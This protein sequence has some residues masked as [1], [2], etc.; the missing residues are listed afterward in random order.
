MTSV[1][2]SLPDTQCRLD[3]LARYHH[4]PGAVLAVSK[5]S[6][7]LDFA[8]GT[9]NSRTGVRATTD[10]VFQIGSN[11]KLLTT[12]LVMQ[13]VDAGEVDLDVPVRRY[14]PSFELAEQGAADQITL[15]HLLTHTSGIEGDYFE[16][17]GRGDE[18]VGRYVGALQ[19]IGLI[20][21]PGQMWSYCN[22]GFVLAGHVVEKVT[23]LPYH[24]V[25]AE[26]ICEPLGLRQ[27]TVLPER[28]LASR[29]AVG[30]VQGPDQVPVVPPVVLMEAASVPAGSRTVATAAE[31]ATFARMHLAGGTAADGTRLLSQESA[32]AMAR[33][34]VT[35]AR[36]CDAAQET[37]ALGWRLAAG[38][39]GDGD[40][41]RGGG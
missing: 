41:R 3:A 40:R 28:M 24:Q 1:V 27:M 12:T 15:R 10:S 17:F 23:A 9:L 39:G 26:R 4:V 37:Q 21:R 29:C 2:A 16:G 32:R 13:L 8:T 20:H 30:H 7:T 38:G 22:S 36:S 34:Q 25:L 6:E 19:N 31:L 33:A 35:R 14:V 11:T 5:G 18:A